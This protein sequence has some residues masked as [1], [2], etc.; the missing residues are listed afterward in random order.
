[1]Y[2]KVT[3][4]TPVSSLRFLPLDREHRIRDRPVFPAQLVVLEEVRDP[5]HRWTLHAGGIRPSPARELQ[6]R[7]TVVAALDDWDVWCCRSDR[8]WRAA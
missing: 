5:L 6:E 2:L 1:M 7:L 8:G 4:F 3:D